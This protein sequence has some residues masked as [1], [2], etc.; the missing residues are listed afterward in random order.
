MTH[1]TVTVKMGKNFA[2]YF[3]AVQIIG[4]LSAEAAQA[5]RNCTARDT[6]YWDSVKACTDAGDVESYLTKF[7]KNGCY[8]EAARACL[9]RLNIARLLSVCASHAAAN[10]L[11]GGTGQS[12][13]SCY[14]EVLSK[15]P[16]NQRANKGLLHI[17]E[18]YMQRGREA[19]DRGD[20]VAAR[21]HARILY[22]LKPGSK[23]A[24][25]LQS[26]IETAE[27]ANA[28]RGNLEQG[29]FARQWPAGK[30]FQ[31][32]A[33][34]PKMVVV[35]AGTI[36]MGS[37]RNGPRHTM[38]IQRRFAVG[39]YEVTFGEWDACVTNGGCG[40]HRPGDRNWRRDR[41]PV[42]NVNWRD[43]RSYVRWLR[44]LTGQRYR[45]LSEAEWEYAARAGT[46]TA[47]SWGAFVG[48]NRANCK[49]CKSHWGGRKTAEVGSFPANGFGLHDMHGNVRE[50]VADC[51]HGNYR[52][53]PADGS[54]WTTGRNCGSR[55]RR[56]GSWRDGPGR[57]RSSSR[58]KSK[59]KG[60]D[61]KTGFRVALTLSP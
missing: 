48:R 60:R 23:A 31:D 56:G 32:C 39:R 25:E 51:W 3:F 53:A 58:L 19:L 46:R 44:R 34:C 50:W 40:E 26:A 13:A 1:Y 45:L 52:G 57:I 49:G 47:Y 30:R 15:D 33:V 29:R 12:A 9:E 38:T 11:A 55:V 5:Q 41:R 20:T 27:H 59:A 42:I 16:G 7:E 36:T 8:V 21:E 35:P 28:A 4:I 18:T 17:F 22:G 24:A 10:R 37:D 2:S 54:A 14:R 43:A 61:S 6:V